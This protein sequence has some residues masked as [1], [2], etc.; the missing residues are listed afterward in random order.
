[1]R[2][3][4][5]ALWLTNAGNLIAADTFFSQIETLQSQTH[6]EISGLE[7]L[8]DGQKIVTS[9]SLEQQVNQL[10]AGYNNVITRDRQGKIKHIVI[11]SKK[12]KARDNRIQVPTQVKDNHATVSVSISG[13]GRNWQTL[14]MV[15][16]TG[17]DVVVLPESMIVQLGLAENTLK[18]NKMQTANGVVDAKIGELQEIMIAGESIANVEAAFIPDRLL[19]E[20]RLLGMSVLGRFQLS[21]D[22]KQHTVTLIRKSTE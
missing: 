1:M 21:I 12:E 2:L 16:D 17:A 15:L 19:G 7:K 22:D 10:F 14:D 18:V 5:F 9:G 3:L 6:L 4:T 11:L 20:N 13:D 8:Q